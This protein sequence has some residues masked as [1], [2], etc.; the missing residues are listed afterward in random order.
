MFSTKVLIVTIVLIFTGISFN[1]CKSASG[2]ADAER[3]VN[4]LVTDKSY[5]YLSTETCKD[6]PDCVRRAFMSRAEGYCVENELDQEDCE[7]VV[8]AR[9]SIRL[10]QVAEK[11]G[12]ETR[13]L[14]EKIQRHQQKK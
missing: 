14:L 2:E 12:E 9:V 6:K 10:L 3:F 1:G 5:Y 13:Q 8:K 11:E 7:I 4:Q